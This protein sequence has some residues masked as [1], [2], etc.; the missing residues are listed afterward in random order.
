MGA[1]VSDS[2]FIARNHLLQKRSDYVDILSPIL[3]KGLFW[4]YETKSKVKK[5]IESN[6]RDPLNFAKDVDV[7]LRKGKMTSTNNKM[8]KKS[9]NGTVA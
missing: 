2:L 8:T 9:W 6:T 7:K 1:V 5:R 3:I 4:N